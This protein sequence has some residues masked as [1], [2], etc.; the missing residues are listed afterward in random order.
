MH[1][2]LLARVVV[3]VVICR[4]AADGAGAVASAVAI[5]FAL[6][7]IGRMRPLLP[8][9]KVAT[10][11]AATKVKTA[12]LTSTTIVTTTRARAMQQ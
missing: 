3:A 12:T 9:Y 11:A 5:T 8:G 4:V 7:A 6:P 2:G 10:A 1:L